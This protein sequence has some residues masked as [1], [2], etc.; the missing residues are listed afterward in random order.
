MYSAELFYNTGFNSVN[1][2]DSELTLRQ[3]ADNI[4]MFP[5]LDILQPTGQTSVR[6]KALY[7]QVIGADYLLLRSQE[8][9][10]LYC[11]YAITSA[12]IMTSVD[13][14]TLYIVE[15]PL[16]TAGG[17]DNIEFL[18]GITSRHHIA[19]ED[20]E[21]GAFIEDDPYLT[22]TETPD[23]YTLDLFDTGTMGEWQ[24]VDGPVMVITATTNLEEMSPSYMSKMTTGDPITGSG[25]DYVFSGGNSYVY[26]PTAPTETTQFADIKPTFSTM[27]TAGNTNEESPIEGRDEYPDGAIGYSVNYE[28]GVEAFGQYDLISLK[29]EINTMVGL[30]LESVVVDAVMLPKSYCKFERSLNVPYSD[31]WYSRGKPNIG[32]IQAVGSFY[33]AENNEFEYEYDTEIQ[34]KRVLYGKYNNYSL[35]AKATGSSIELSPEDFKYNKGEDSYTIEWGKSPV[36]ICLPDIRTQGRP[37]FNFAHV[38]TSGDSFMNGAISGSQWRKAS[39]TVSVKSGAI[40]DE[41]NFRRVQNEKDFW[42]SNVGQFLNQGGD[43]GVSGMLQYAKDQSNLLVP[44]AETGFN[45][46]FG[47]GEG[48][49]SG[50][51]PESGLMAAASG[52]RGILSQANT[53]KARQQATE[54]F[55]RAVWDEHLRAQRE[56][57]SAY[58][59]AMA[60]DPLALPQ[61]QRE[62]E[63]ALEV[64]SFMQNVSIFDPGF[65][66]NTECNLRDINGN[67]AYFLRKTPTQKDRLRHDKILTQ[68]GYKITE[69]IT[70]A[71]LKNRR[72][73]NYIQAGGVSVEFINSTYYGKYLKERV[74][75]VFSTGVRIWHTKPNVAYYTN[76]ENV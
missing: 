19:L 24:S 67:G 29:N 33:M 70:T 20:D 2:P 18:D 45:T 56:G 38:K 59:A 25:P 12:P 61:Y 16:L 76:G 47:A 30:G 66:I 40:A 17:I 5:A 63:K 15:D 73:F 50:A 36:P 55:N 58:D 37:Y 65:K 41:A 8:Q 3:A 42:A 1:I 10:E 71:M 14:A 7:E 6:L 57:T 48:I 43:A 4:K 52:V 53:N 21:F 75:D 46:V 9:P 64:A 62:R 32:C 60:G 39:I 72:K 28:N 44:I 68:F 27:L 51:G 31:G 26:R 13:V 11:F 35:I 34:N 49:L 74:A 23:Y 54:T 22:L 69:P